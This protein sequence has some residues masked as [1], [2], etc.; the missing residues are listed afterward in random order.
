MYPVIFKEIAEELGIIRNR[1]NAERMRNNGKFARGDREEHASYVGILGE[2]CT[3]YLLSLRRIN[4]K[5][6]PMIDLKPLSEP[7]IWIEDEGFDIKTIREDG[8][9]FLVNVDAHQKHK[10]DNYCFVRLEPRRLATLRTETWET[11]NKWP[12]KNCK[13]TDAYFC[14]VGEALER[15]NVMEWG[16]WNATL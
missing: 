10:A 3:R 4:Y 8:W 2:M 9:D 16:T 14:P 7:D 1:L 12:I 5:T 13:F 6:T 15:A 11:V